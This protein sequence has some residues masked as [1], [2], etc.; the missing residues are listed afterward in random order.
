[1]SEAKVVVAPAS[2]KR[3]RATKKSKTEEAKKAPPSLKDAFVDALFQYQLG[4]PRHINEATIKEDLH[5]LVGKFIGS[6]AFVTILL[7]SAKATKN[8]TDDVEIADEDCVHHLI[9]DITSVLFI[10]DDVH[11]ENLLHHE[12]SALGDIRSRISAD[13]HEF[14]RQVIEQAKPSVLTKL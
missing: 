13:I 1:M 14:V 8:G 11:Q 5:S 10:L 2:N 6:P 4:D 9:E 7:K 12:S 3:K